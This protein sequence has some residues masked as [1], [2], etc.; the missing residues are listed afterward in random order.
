[1]HPGRNKELNIES[2]VTDIE[3]TILLLGAHLHPI[4][5]FRT[6]QI[7]STI[8]PSIC[9][10]AGVM[11]SV[12]PQTIVNIHSS[13]FMNTQTGVSRLGLF[14]IKTRT[15]LEQQRGRNNLQVLVKRL[16]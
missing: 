12:I 14:F 10:L 6:H 9:H 7:I 4:S 5:V 8:G 16:L 3:R 15:G 2:P 11:K 13:M 1:M